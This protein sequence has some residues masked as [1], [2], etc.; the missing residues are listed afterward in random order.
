ML[1]LHQRWPK[2][3]A[4][5]PALLAVRLVGAVH[6]GI[7]CLLLFVLLSLAAAS[8]WTGRT[9][10]LVLLIWA[11]V[12]V[13]IVPSL[14]ALGRGLWTL[15]AEAYHMAVLA[16]SLLLAIG[17]FNGLA[18]GRWDDGAVGV[19]LSALTL[20]VLLTP[21][22]HRLFFPPGWLALL[23]WREWAWHRS[24]ALLG[25]GIVSWALYVGWLSPPPSEAQARRLILAALERSPRVVAVDGQG[26]TLPR[27]DE[28]LQFDLLT[29]VRGRGVVVFHAD[30]IE[31]QAALL[32]GWRGWW[33][34]IETVGPRQH[35]QPLAFRDRYAGD[36]AIAISPLVYGT[37]ALPDAVAVS[38]T[39]A[40]G[41]AQ[42]QELASGRFALL[43][44]EGIPPCLL[45]VED[46]A[47]RV[48]VTRTLTG[49]RAMWERFGAA[50][51]RCE[52]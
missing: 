25:V 33:A 32:R 52:V 46:G 38:V 2:L 30:T 21:T 9:S 8:L 20:L 31:G 22:V 36:L 13:T 42:R 34:R 50:G 1:M 11:L 37:V 40:D 19:S 7:A 49:S 23:S 15:T 26:E 17:L 16:H 18:E 24:S 10:W 14:Y 5:S 45:R 47:A 43:G 39:Y 35:S 29:F 48:L 6:I 44:P 4:T 28:Q 27:S 51:S 12:G 3:R 41:T